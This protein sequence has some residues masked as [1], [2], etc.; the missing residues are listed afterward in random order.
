MT[1]NKE[2]FNTS[3]FTKAHAGKLSTS[4]HLKRRGACLINTAASSLKEYM[5]LLTPATVA[6]LD[7]A[8]KP[9][10]IHG[11]KEMRTYEAIAA[12]T[13]LCKVM[14]SGKIS[15]AEWEEQKAVLVEV[16]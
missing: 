3:V 8:A 4:N 7:A 5:Q 16:I 2:L 15:S 1:R 10:I 14:H 6:N 9:K 11:T 13:K 12:L